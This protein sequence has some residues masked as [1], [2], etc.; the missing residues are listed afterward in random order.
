MFVNQEPSADYVLTDQRRGDNLMIRLLHIDAS[1]RL[2]R[3]HSR[4]LSK[5]FVDAWLRHR[6][7]DEIIVRDLGVSSPAPV[8]HAWIEAAFTKPEKRTEL[9]QIA[10]KESDALV[11]ELQSSDLIVAGVPMYNFG[12]PAPM[13]AYIDNI[14]RV[15]RT[16]GFDRGRAG[17]PYWPLLQG[18]RLVIL[19]ARGDAGYSPGGCLEHM[20]HVEPHL[21]TAF[22]YIGITDVHSVAVEFDEFTDQRVKRSIEEAEQLVDRLVEDLIRSCVEKEAAC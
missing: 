6:P 16:F 11:D 10:L 5:R 19:S 20:N 12:V 8:D 22:G 2:T 9:M 1:A 18:K 17:A 14:V 21:C 15:G 13:K 7:D 3:S 4:H